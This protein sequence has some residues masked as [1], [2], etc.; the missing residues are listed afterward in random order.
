MYILLSGVPPFY[1]KT[2]EDILKKVIDGRFSLRGNGDI[3]E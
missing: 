2:D 1:G 3:K